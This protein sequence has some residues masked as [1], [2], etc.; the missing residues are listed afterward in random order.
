MSIDD[1]K[2]FL[3]VDGTDDDTLIQAEID[4]VE[5]Y[6]E[7]AVTNFS[8]LY[9]DDLKFKAKADICMMAIIA[10]LYEDRAS[11]H[12]GDYSYAIRS[13]INQ[14]ALTEA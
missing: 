13:M 6:M 8:T 7:S 1:V 5:A 14:L 2:Q 10:Q 12:N 4:A 11:T 3:R 9:S